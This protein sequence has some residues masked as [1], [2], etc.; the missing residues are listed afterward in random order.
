MKVRFLVPV[1]LSLILAA[2]GRGGT[3]SEIE[4]KWG[5]LADVNEMQFSSMPHHTSGLSLYPYRAY[6][7][8]LQR[9][10]NQDPIQEAGG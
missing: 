6:E 8:N 9:W 1:L 2:C 4:G 7:P 3:P 10:M 5:A